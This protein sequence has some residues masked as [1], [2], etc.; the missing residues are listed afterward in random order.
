MKKNNQKAAAILLSLL[1]LSALLVIAFGISSLSLGEIKLV[2]DIPKS[3]IA[4]YSAD[5]GIEWVM[6][7]ERQMGG[8]TTTADCSVLLGN[9]ISYGINEVKRSGGIVTIKVTGCYDNI[10]RAIQI[11]F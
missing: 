8:A 2:R 11:S 5:S 7:E 9:G 6:Y 4:Y 3:L 10:R 1:I